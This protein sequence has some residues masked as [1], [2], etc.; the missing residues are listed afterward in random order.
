[1]GV[2]TRY[3]KNPAGFRQIVELMESAP[4]SRRQKMIDAGMKE[5]PE[6]TN[7]IL[8]F[9]FTFEDLIQLSDLELAELLAGVPAQ[10]MAY[11]IHDQ[12]KEVQ[13]RWIAHSSPQVLI[14]VKEVLDNPKVSSFQMSAG[15]VKM[16]AMAR[17]LERKGYIKT[18]AIP[19]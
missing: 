10:W 7:K 19:H 9:V 3:K 18:K 8:Q 17:S 1:M 5:D 14:E 13:A 16:I 2:Y 12:S 6:Y 11:A 15:K 4:P